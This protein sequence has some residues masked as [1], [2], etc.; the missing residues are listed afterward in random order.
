M[1]QETASDVINRLGLTRHDEGGWY[2]ETYRSAKTVPCPDRDGGTRSLMTTI[3]YLIER[4][5]PRG[6]LHRNRSDIMHF[7]H[8]GGV[9]CYVT[10]G[11]EGFAKHMVGPGYLSQLMV[12]G[13]WWKATELVEG[14]WA[15][16][17]EAVSPGFDYRDR[18]L[19]QKSDVLGQYPAHLGDV[20]VYL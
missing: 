16:V 15:L 13:G 18:E 19:A 9:L 17:G 2:S 14:D 8:G 3:H 10:L 5:A 4:E 7:H 1:P 6:R 11:P 20:A 12:P